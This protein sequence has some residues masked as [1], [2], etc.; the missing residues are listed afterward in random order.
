MPVGV[1]TYALNY[2]FWKVSFMCFLREDLG[3]S[4]YFGICYASRYRNLD[5]SSQRIVATSS[6]I[7]KLLF[8]AS[9]PTA[10]YLSFSICFTIG[11]YS[12]VALV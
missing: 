2:A 8:I 3:S 10:S 5:F 12:A 9:I 11:K 6:S 1:S 4:T 7:I